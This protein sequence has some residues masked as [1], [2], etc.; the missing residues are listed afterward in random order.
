MQDS[1]SMVNLQKSLWTTT[2]ALTNRRQQK[3]HKFA[4]L[5]MKNSIFAR[6]A[7]AFFTF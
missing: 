2:P 7:R 6:F 5:T 1:W 4:Y 3:R